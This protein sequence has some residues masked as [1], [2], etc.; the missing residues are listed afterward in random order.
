G[1]S[2]SSG[3]GGGGAGAGAAAAGGDGGG[4]GGFAYTPEI[5]AL[6]AFLRS[7]AATHPLLAV[8]PDQQQV[9]VIAEFRNATG[10]S[11]QVVEQR[12]FIG[13][14][15]VRATGTVCQQPD[16]RWALMR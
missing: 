12:V 2:G 14:A 3:A 7:P 4:G 8:A 6:E 11:C 9:R 5:S 15:R 16:G 13:G 1:G 10:Q